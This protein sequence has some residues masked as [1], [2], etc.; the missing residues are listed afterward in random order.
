MAT[1]IEKLEEIIATSSN[2][3]TVAKA[4]DM[5]DQENRRLASIG[6]AQVQA[7]AMTGVGDADVVAVLEAIKSALKSSGSG[8]V[9]M[10]DL[11]KEM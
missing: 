10:A 8:N 2:P 9:N 6:S 7:A 3:V 5:L 4:Q 11:R 1:Q